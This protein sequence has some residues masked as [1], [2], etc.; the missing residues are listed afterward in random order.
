MYHGFVRAPD[1]TITTF[2]VPGAIT[3]PENNL[4]AQGTRPTGIN[5]AGNITGTYLDA[6]YTY[7][8]FVRAANGSITTFDA[9]GAGDGGS[10]TLPLSID[11]A[12]DIAG[13]YFDSGSQAHGFVLLANTS[14][15]ITGFEHEFCPARICSGY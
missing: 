14:G 6:N 4:Y 3:G 1:G 5:A 15:K 11:A 9:L 10:G 13:A 7:H 2:D 12:G 8:G